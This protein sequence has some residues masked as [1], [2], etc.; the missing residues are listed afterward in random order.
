MV[1]ENI[2][3]VIDIFFII[4]GLII[5]FCYDGLLVVEN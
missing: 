1:I 2:K 3:D 4:K 5:L